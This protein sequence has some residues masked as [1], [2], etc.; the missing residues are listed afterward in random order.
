[1]GRRRA[2]ARARWPG[3]PDRGRIVAVADVFYPQLS[4]RSYRP[5]V[6]TIRDG[7]GSQFDPRVADLLLDNLERHFPSAANSGA[8]AVWRR[9][10]YP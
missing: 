10:V 4:D 2:P 8:E 6:A 9:S 3:D 5:A 1:M 7:R